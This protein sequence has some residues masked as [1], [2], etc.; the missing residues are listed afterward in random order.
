MKYQAYYS[1][2]RHPSGNPKSP[3]GSKNRSDTDTRASDTFIVSKEKGMDEHIKMFSREWHTTKI[4]F[5]FA[6]LFLDERK[7]FCK[8]RI[9]YLLK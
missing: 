3:D 5:H 6:A 2:A 8:S 1:N 9:L 7:R 4:Y